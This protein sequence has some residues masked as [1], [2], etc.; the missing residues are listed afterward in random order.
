MQTALRVLRKQKKP[1]PKL[2]VDT[3]PFQVSAS[4]EKKRGFLFSLWLF[5]FFLFIDTGM[6]KGGN[7]ERKLIFSSQKQHVDFCILQFT[8]F[9]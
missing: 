4:P 3:V 2:C 7:A 6:E 8:S 1:V 5:F 9:F